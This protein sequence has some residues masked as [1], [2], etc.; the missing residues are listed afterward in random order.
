MII[1]N[2]FFHRDFLEEVYLK[3]SPGCTELGSRLIVQREGEKLN[4]TTNKVCKLNYS[5]C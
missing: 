2:A 4:N 5:P 3:M 1:E